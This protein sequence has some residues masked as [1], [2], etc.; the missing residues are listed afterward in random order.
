MASDKCQTILNEVIYYGCPSWQKKSRTPKILWSIVQLICFIF[1]PI[2]LVYIILRLCKEWCGVTCQECRPD[3]GNGD[4]QRDCCVSCRCHKCDGFPLLFEHPYSKF[5]NH[6]VFY[7]VF[8]GFLIAASFEEEF[9]T[10]DSGIVCIGQKNLLFFFSHSDFLVS[11]HSQHLQAFAILSI[12][13]NKVEIKATLAM[14]CL[15]FSNSG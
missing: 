2:P 9:G 14:P 12:I 6:T 1:I 4:G 5:V 3:R 11:C 7:L 8:L 15:F 10:T 13:D